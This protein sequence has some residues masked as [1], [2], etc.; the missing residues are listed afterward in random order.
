MANKCNTDKC[1][2]R[3]EKVIAF[4]MG[5]S[6]QWVSLVSN[7]IVK[8]SSRKA[9]CSDLIFVFRSFCNRDRMV[10]FKFWNNDDSGTMGL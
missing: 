9:T 7:S 10:G 5:L 4:T 8:C 3:V 6:V 1:I 2:N